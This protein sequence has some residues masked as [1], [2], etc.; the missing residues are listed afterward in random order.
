LI[1]LRSFKGGKE[2]RAGY[3]QKEIAEAFQTRGVESNEK[4]R[5]VIENRSPHI[6]SWEEGGKAQIP[7]AD[8]PTERRR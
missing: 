1:T 6:L 3:P 8:L 7:S 4:E 2:T 5:V